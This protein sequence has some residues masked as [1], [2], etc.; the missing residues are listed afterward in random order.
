VSQDA[1]IYTQ[2]VAER[3]DVP[4]QVRIEAERTLQAL[5]QVMRSGVPS[6]SLAVRPVMSLSR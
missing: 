1:P 5:E 4:A 6:P 3:G 2:L